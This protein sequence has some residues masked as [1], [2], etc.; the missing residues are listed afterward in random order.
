ME[1]K[2]TLSVF[3]EIVNNT[4]GVHSAGCRH[5]SSRVQSKETGSAA[6]SGNCVAPDSISA[7]GRLISPPFTKFTQTEVA[8]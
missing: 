6:P 3:H 8:I 2:T 1:L 7:A 5:H 4:Q